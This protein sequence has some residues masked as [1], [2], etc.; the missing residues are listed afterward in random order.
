MGRDHSPVFSLQ[1]EDKEKH[2]RSL[3]QNIQQV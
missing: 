1:W 2:M 3:G